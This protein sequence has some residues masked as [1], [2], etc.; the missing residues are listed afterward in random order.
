[1]KLLPTRGETGQILAKI[2]YF[3]Q[4]LYFLIAKINA[5]FNSHMAIM[6]TDSVGTEK[7]GQNFS[8]FTDLDPSN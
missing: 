1:M 7:G 8:L 3:L 6:A 2:F 5:L 4:K